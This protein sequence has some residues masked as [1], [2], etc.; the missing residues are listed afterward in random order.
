MTTNC[1]CRFCEGVLED[2]NCVIRRCNATLVVKPH[3]LSKLLVM[4]LQE[5]N[6]LN[7]LQLDYFPEEA[8]SWDVLFSAICWYIWKRINKRIFYETFYEYDN[9]L[10][11]S[12]QLCTMTSSYG[13]VGSFDNSVYKI[14][15]G[16]KV[17]TDG[18]VCK[19]ST[20]A[21]VGGTVRDDLGRWIF[22]FSKGIGSCLVL[23]AELC[24]RSL[25]CDLPRNLVYRK[26]FWRPT[27]LL[28]SNC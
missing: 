15:I 18:V 3:T 23:E 28:L 7:L 5:C 20:F 14:A 19:E 8:G 1:D 25:A 2:D 26:L 16:C 21:I 27:I 10:D 11:R 4:G 9:V 24:E 22:G 13:G 6:F 17:N 12:A